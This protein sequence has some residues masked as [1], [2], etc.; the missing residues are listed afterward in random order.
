VDR[1]GTD[2]E[3]IQLMPPE[4]DS[5]FGRAA[6]AAVNLFKNTDVM[7]VNAIY[8][9]GGWR[10]TECELIHLRRQA[11]A[12]AITVDDYG[13]VSMRRRLGLEMDLPARSTSSIGQM[14]DTVLNRIRRHV[15]A[16]NAGFQGLSEGVR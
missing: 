16:W 7:D 4:C 1:T 12:V 15:E 5:D 3:M 9:V 6:K 13:S 8:I 10:P 14:G 11:R 2:F